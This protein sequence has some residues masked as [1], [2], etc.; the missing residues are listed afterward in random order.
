MK[1]REDLLNRAKKIVCSDRDLQYGSPEDSFTQ[2]A[3]F[4]NAYLYPG[5]TQ[6]IKA[7]DVGMMMILLKIA[8][9][10]H[11]PK[12]D[13]LIDIAGYAAC[14]GEIERPD[15]LEFV[16]PPAAMPRESISEDSFHLG[17]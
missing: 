3:E 6:S 9:Q 7:K 8:R 13:N 16:P 10:S 5:Q 2:I 17:A 1:T 14:V 12:E 15:N 11:K 4:W